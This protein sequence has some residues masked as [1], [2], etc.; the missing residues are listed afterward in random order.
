MNFIPAFAAAAPL[1]MLALSGIVSLLAL[2]FAKRKAE[3]SFSV[4]AIGLVLAIVLSFALSLPMLPRQIEGLLSID[5]LSFI[6]T[7]IILVSS[8][9]IALASRPYLAGR[10]GERGEYY[11]LLQFATLGAS[12]LA[13]SSNLASLFLGLELLSVSLYALVAYQRERPEGTRA[14]FTYLILASVASAFLLFGM[15]LA[16]FQ[17]G[18]LE[19]S[20]ITPTFGSGPADGSG[21]PEGTPLMIAAFAMMGVGFAFKLAVA[22]FHMWAPEVYEG[23]GAPVTSLIATVSKAAMAIPL[24]RV[25]APRLLSSASGGGASTC[26]WIVAALSGA[27]MI[28]G[29]LLALKEERVKRM[30]AGSSITQIGYILVALIAGGEYGVSA[31]LFYL[32]AYSL[33]TLGA[34]ACVAAVSASEGG[35]E[36][37]STSLEDFRGLASRR[38]LVAVAMTASLLSLAGMP[39]T[40]GFIGKFMLFSAGLRGGA[41]TC[42]LAILLALNSAVSLFYYL[43]LVSLMYRRPEVK[44]VVATEGPSASGTVLASPRG[45]FL[46][47]VMLAL[48]G[49]SILL[50]GTAPGTVLSLISSLISL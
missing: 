38:P 35:S 28:V 15:A 5:G 8:L 3:V 32:A 41:A 44:P 46:A 25:L 23:A 6:G 48:I 4:C 19:L 49:L 50:L 47:G 43:R 31:A 20:R 10:E 42:M 34:F 39:L 29:N 27:S 40:V 14:A 16:Y 36:R 22:P 45:S 12:V 2:S 30:L 11:V 26:V 13:A 24:I 33:S 18:S 9:A 37:G 7:E 21:M 17:A 1:V